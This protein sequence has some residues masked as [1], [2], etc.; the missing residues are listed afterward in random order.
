[1]VFTNYTVNERFKYEM[2]KY[3]IEGKCPRV[4]YAA[5]FVFN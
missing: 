1:M 2:G 3:S 4:T 5:S